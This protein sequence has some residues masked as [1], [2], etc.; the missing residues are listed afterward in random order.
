MIASLRPPPA[1]WIAVLALL[2]GLGAPPRGVAQDEAATPAPSPAADAPTAPERG[3]APILAAGPIDYRPG[4]GL[5]LGSTG[6]TIGGFTNVKGEYSAEAHGEFSLDLLNFFVI[7]DKIPRFRAVAELQLKDIFTVNSDAVGAQDF[8]FDVRRLF[9][10]YTVADQLH[11]R[12]GTFLTPVGYWNLILAPPLTWTSELPLIVEETFF[13]ETTTGVMAYGAN[14]LGPGYLNYAAFSQFLQPLADDPDLDP[15]DVTAGARLVYDTGPAWS[16]GLTFQAAEQTDGWTQLG[17]VHAIWQ[18]SRGEVLAELYAQAGPGLPSAQWGTYLQGVF[19]LWGPFYAVGRYEY[20]D[21]PGAVAPVNLFLAG[22]V[23]KPFPFMA[24]K[25]E[26][27]LADRRL[28]G[29][30]L[31]GFFASFTTFF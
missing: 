2:V 3:E 31:D 11:V 23:A 8:A 10:D 13:A 18:P 6:L 15:P 21:P 25:V 16:A 7:F 24:L 1:A 4:R 29:V 20:Y 27:R 12:A 19:N 22:A 5:H 30:D 17:A 26:Y 14:E 9:G 28:D